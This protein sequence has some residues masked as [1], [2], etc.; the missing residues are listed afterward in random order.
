MPIERLKHETIHLKDGR[1]AVLSTARLPSGEYET[2]LLGQDGDEIVAAKA[3]GEEEALATFRY[4]KM[5]Y[6][7]PV[8]KGRYTTGSPAPSMG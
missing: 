5:V 4:F 3:A 2:M 1:Y 7:S 8:L 6:S